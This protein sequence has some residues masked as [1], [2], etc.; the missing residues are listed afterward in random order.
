MVTGRLEAAAGEVGTGGEDGG[1]PE[2]R[3]AG[4][5]LSMETM[6]CLEPFNIVKVLSPLSKTS[7]GPS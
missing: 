6:S 7:K 5:S 2:R 3:V 4:L 1:G